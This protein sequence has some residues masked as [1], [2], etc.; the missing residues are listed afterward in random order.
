M[1]VNRL[2]LRIDPT[3]RNTN[4][5]NINLPIDITT[6]E[7]GRGDLVNQYESDT[8][9]KI[10]GLNK[11]YEVTRYSQS[12]LQNGDPTPNLFM[13]FNFG[14]L[15]SSNPF[16]VLYKKLPDVTTFN[17]V[18]NSRCI[19]GLEEESLEPIPIYTPYN[20]N[21]RT[22]WVGY[23]YQGFLPKETYSITE[24]FSKSFFKLDFYDTP[25]R[26]KQKLYM[27]L[28]INPIN[29]NDIYRPT[30]KTSNQ[31]PLDQPD[32]RYNCNPDAE[33]NT[34]TPFF[35]LDPVNNSEGYHIYWLKEKTFLDLDVF[36]LQAKF[37]NAKTGLVTQFINTPQN[38]IPNPF[39]FSKTDYFYYRV[40][41]DQNRYTYTYYRTSD[42]LRVG[43]EESSPI[44]FYQYFNP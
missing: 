11:D 28:V 19:E 22:T 36:F 5:R 43:A 26:S 1:D 38:E 18:G 16:N 14:N 9:I 29:G 10:L 12:P 40:K 21:D 6:D 24:T 31:L 34:P 37:F 32:G 17:S 23:D 30:L 44:N 33:K 39:S 20:P 2:K 4:D 8:L 42:G 25:I 15:L 3:G 13:N 27:T 7:L 35:E 41:L